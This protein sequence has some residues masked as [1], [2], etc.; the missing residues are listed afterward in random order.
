MDPDRYDDERAIERLIASYGHLLDARR[1]SV[2]DGIFAPE[3]SLTRR[4]PVSLRCTASWRSKITGQVRTFSTRLA[5]TP[6]VPH[7]IY[8]LRAKQPSVG[9]N[10]RRDSSG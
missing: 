5:I 9:G 7:H 1:W 4:R 3:A 10:H 6:W 8:N 2:L